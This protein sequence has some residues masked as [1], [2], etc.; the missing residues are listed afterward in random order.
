MLSLLC[1]TSTLAVGINL[2]AHLVIIKSTMQY[3]TGGV[4]ATN[5]S[6]YVEYSEFDV[7]QMVG[8]AGRP[9]FDS[10]GIAVILTQQSTVQRYE[11][12]L[13]GQTAVES[14][15]DIFFIFALD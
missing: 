3:S 13:Q 10:V 12:L 11:N 15:Y 14:A 4:H 9:Q 7:L 1:A 8:R 2:P 5:A 6:G